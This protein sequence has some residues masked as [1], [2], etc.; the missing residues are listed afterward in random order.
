MKIDVDI[1]RIGSSANARVYS[2]PFA[3]GKTIIGRLGAI[4]RGMSEKDIEK[5][6]PNIKA[7]IDDFKR[8]VAECKSAL[9]VYV[10]G[11]IVWGDKQI[12]RLA[13]CVGYVRSGK[14]SAE[15]FK[16]KILQKK[17]YAVA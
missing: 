5:R 10:K 11:T 4:K 17:A 16:N 12:P 9:G 6:Y 15:D 7:Q 14:G 13:A 3:P 1:L 2:H 8:A